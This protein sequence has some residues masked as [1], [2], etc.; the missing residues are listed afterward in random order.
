MGWFDVARLLLPWPTPGQ[1][2]RR[3]ELGEEAS[4]LAGFQLFLDDFSAAMLEASAWEQL[5]QAGLD[6]LHLGLVSGCEQL[7]QARSE[8]G[9][10]RNWQAPSR[11]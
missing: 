4:I 11:A 7:R 6:Y 5:R 1:T 10:S 3:S 9:P 2:K 8:P